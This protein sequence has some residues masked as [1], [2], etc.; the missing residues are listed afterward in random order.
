MS[1]TLDAKP[2]SLR[3]SKTPSNG[4]IVSTATMAMSVAMSPASPKVRIR[5]DV[6]NCKAMN[7]IPAVAW[8]STQAGPAMSRALRKAVNLSSPAIRRSRAAKVSCMLS[9][10]LI[11]MMSGVITFKKMFRRK[12][13]QPSVP[14]AS[15]M[16]A[17]GGAAA[18]IMNDTRRKNR[19]AIRQP[20]A[21]PSAL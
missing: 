8:V 19:T 2:A 20:A 4:T 5:S 18:M 17:S 3:M 9:E 7:E 12:S 21:N 13:S 10:K 14:S 1:R 11:T 16:A 15:R 6:E